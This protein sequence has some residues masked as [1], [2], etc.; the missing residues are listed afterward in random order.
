VENQNQGMNRRDFLKAVGFTVV[1]GT[2]LTE[3]FLASCKNSGDTGPISMGSV[4]D[5]S[6]ELAGM[7][8][9]ISQGVKLAVKQKNDAGGIG[10][11]QIT[12]FTE[13]GGTDATTSFTAFKKLAE[14]NGCKVI[15]GPM[16]SGAVEACAEYALANKILLISPS[17]TS[18]DIAN[19]AYRQFVFRTAALDTLQGQAI[20]KLVTDGGYKKVALLVVNNSYGE[21]LEDVMEAQLAGKTTIVTQLQYDPKKLDYLTE[22]QTIKTSAPDCVVHV[23]YGDDADVVYKQALQLGIT[24][25]KWIASEGV[26]AEKTLT[27]PE[28]A[29]FMAANVTG[30]R[31]TAPEGLAANATF[32]A[33]FKAAYGA[34]PGSYSDTAY[35]AV[36]MAIAAMKVVGSTDATK[37]AAEVLKEAKAYPGASGAIT[38]ASNGDRVSGDYEVWKVVKTGSTYAYGK[39][40]VISLS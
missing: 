9:V 14:V 21:G 20:A 30:T 13:D 29:E 1:G 27:V 25:A 8:G 18:P 17:A 3:A 28:A 2:L 15:I 39:V 31:P 7:G 34:E 5:L 37:I 6:G 26:Y 35:D 32:V 12:L 36:N 10:G 40:K 24:S 38:L 16:T 11:R 33:A 23:G 4:M 22:L 19:Q